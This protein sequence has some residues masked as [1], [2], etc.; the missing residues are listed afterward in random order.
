MIKWFIPSYPKKIE[1]IDSYINHL[2]HIFPND[3][4]KDKKIVVDLSNGAT[5]KTT[6]IVLEKLGAK[7]HILNSGTGKIN[8]RVGSEYPQFLSHQVK[9]LNADFGFAHDGDG[10]RVIFCGSR[11]EIIPGDKILG[12]LAIHEE[13]KGRLTNKGLVATIHSNSGLDASLKSHGIDL[14]RTDVG[15]RNVAKLMRDRNINLGGE[16]SGHIVASNY[17][18]TGDGLL[19]ALMTARASYE[20]NQSIDY[21]SNQII[22]W[23]CIEGSFKVKEK[24]PISNCKDLHTELKKW[25]ISL[26]TKVDY[27]C[28]IQAQNRKLDYLL[29]LQKNRKLRKHLLILQK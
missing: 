13:K 20:S 11:G 26:K 8:D 24:V 10:D 18:P 21:L 17:L 6:P 28:A 22:L 9:H 4:L 25:K 23:P 14:L 15:D 5:Q 19:S 29:K 27:C 3:L 7:I 1:I 12:L 16:S 2:L